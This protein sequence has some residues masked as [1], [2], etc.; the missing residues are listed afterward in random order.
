ML[1]G[2][3]FSDRKIAQ[4]VATQRVISG[5]VTP[6]ASAV[7]TEKTDPGEDSVV[8]VYSR[9]QDDHFWTGKTHGIVIPDPLPI[10]FRVTVPT[11]TDAQ[12]LAG[13]APVPS[14]TTGQLQKQEEQ[15][16]E[17]LYKETITARAPVVLP[18][19]LIS[20][21]MTGD[22]QIE[23]LTETLDNGLQ[24]ISPNSLTVEADVQNLGNNQSLK[25]VGLVD[26]VFAK[27][28]AETAIHDLIPPKYLGI[29]PTL[30]FAT[31]VAGTITNPPVL[32]AGDLLRREEQETEYK[33][34]A[35]RRYRDLTTLPVTLIEYKMT[36]EKQIETLTATLD[37]GLQTLTGQITALT[38]EANVD[39]LGNNLSLKE[40][41][42][43]P[44]LFGG[45]S[46]GKAI[47]NPLP[48]EFRQLV[49]TYTTEETFTGTIVDPPVF[50]PGDIEKTETQV[51]PFTKRVRIE[52]FSGVALPITLTGIYEVTSQFG[53][54]I[55]ATTITLDN[56][57]MTVDTGLMVL[58]SEIRNLGTSG[59]YL[60]ITKEAATDISWP[61]L[62]ESLFDEEMQIRISKEEQVV[63]P[64][65]TPVDGTNFTE[66][67]RA[68]DK[69]RS[70]R[71]RTTKAP[72]ATNEGNALVSEIFAPFQFPGTVNA[73]L[74]AQS[75]AY[76]GYRAVK[77][78]F[79][80]QILKTWWVN[81]PT[82]P[83]IA[84][85]NI[86]TNSI[87]IA[88]VTRVAQFHGVLHDG[89]VTQI[90]FAV[91]QF[92]PTTPTFTEY[93]LGTPSGTF[94]NHNL[95]V[96]YTPGTGYTLGDVLTI[97]G[98]G[99][100][101]QIQVTGL[102]VSNS[103][104]GYTIASEG[105]G[106]TYTNPVTA[107]GGSGTGAQFNVLPYSVP[108]YVPGTAWVGT[109]RVVSADIKQTEIKEQ[110]KIQIRIVEM[111]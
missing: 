43:V 30:E 34:R 92:A 46:S 10:R 70:R 24:T 3:Q 80:S 69:W 81:S 27:Q 67:K 2:K 73:L 89:W 40:L 39:N 109:P 54:T 12:N 101:A 47:P 72:T 15:L 84:F 45:K 44:S 33:Y 42:T 9:T 100:S 1:T 7:L 96:L 52:T 20:Y 103:I 57:P 91:E 79:V 58:S 98:T 75:N 88:G 37:T 26:S 14:L 107:T 68:I 50:S 48:P 59:F 106:G 94:T 31:T 60:K 85:D 78:E 19:T 51:D 21:K 18:V 25:S 76:L 4:T 82:K 90:G 77:A 41:G 110:W 64:T 56:A 29:L 86:I 17:F 108:N 16:D 99:G 74:C 95:I 32:A 23:T 83:V 6:A 5:S 55:A 63:D 61:T 97:P 71:L 65:Y 87:T 93:Y 111:R 49:P 8:D 66:S 13:T 28:A 36:R 22:Q 62:T 11:V 53:G 102:G 105:L 104:T 35:T 38:I